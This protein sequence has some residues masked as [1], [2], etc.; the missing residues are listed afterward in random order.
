MNYDTKLIFNPFTCKLD[1]YKQLN[2]D[3]FNIL[4]DTRNCLVSAT[5]G[6][7]VMESSTT[8]NTV[9]V[10][11]DNTDI[12]PVFG[13]IISKPTTT[14]CVI[15]L[16]GVIAGFGGLTKGRKIY[17]STSGSLTSTPPTTGY[18]QSLGVAKESD[19]I[20]FYPNM[21]RVKRI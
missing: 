7:L 8:I 9:D 3:E 10:V 6:D 14:T 15:L 13:I 5:I 16:L 4:T 21:Q 20:D 1:L 17:L 19:E 18:L 11:T 12:R 2:L